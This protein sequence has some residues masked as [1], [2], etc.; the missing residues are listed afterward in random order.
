MVPTG[1][2]ADS[3]RPTSGHTRRGRKGPGVGQ[4]TQERAAGEGR[5]E[6][7]GR[8]PEKPKQGYV[9]RVFF[10]SVVTLLWRRHRVLARPDVMMSKAGGIS[11]GSLLHVLVVVGRVSSLMIRSLLCSWGGLWLEPNHTLGDAA[12]FYALSLPFFFSKPQNYL[13]LYY[14]LAVLEYN[15][16]CISCGW[17]S[18]SWLQKLFFLLLCAETVWSKSSEWETTKRKDG[19]A[20]IPPPPRPSASIPSWTCLKS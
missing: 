3:A 4:Q 12:S 15:G 8:R 17:V 9:H 6:I 19:A 16:F 18:V 20:M 11:T 1:N 10:I 13:V 7:E 2:P 5:G 14:P